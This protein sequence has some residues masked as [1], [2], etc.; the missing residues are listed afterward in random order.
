MLPSQ[1]VGLPGNGKGQSDKEGSQKL[2]MF[3]VQDDGTTW[4]LYRRDLYRGRMKDLVGSTVIDYGYGA[5]NEDGDGTG[6]LRLGVLR[7]EEYLARPCVH[8]CGSLKESNTLVGNESNTLV[9]NESNTL[10]GARIGEV[11][12]AQSEKIPFPNA[13]EP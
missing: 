5:T 10:V 13:V 9:G 8:G 4:E 1:G 11:L 3:P 6:Y 12:V 2:H 7:V